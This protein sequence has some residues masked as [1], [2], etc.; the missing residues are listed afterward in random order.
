MNQKH[1]N[2]QAVFTFSVTNPNYQLHQ[3]PKSPH[4]NAPVH[5]LCK[6]IDAVMS[7]A[8]EAETGAGFLN[9]KDAIHLRI[10]LEEMGHPQGPTP[11][12]FDNKVAT[13]LLNDDATQKRSKAMDMRFYW[14]KDRDVQKQFHIHWRPGSTNLADYPTKHHPTSHHT[15]VR[16]NY[17]SNLIELKNRCTKLFGP[18]LQGCAKSLSPLLPPHNKTN[19][20]FQP[21]L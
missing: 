20:H 19:G 21:T 15:T 3:I 6:I 12:Q 10:A 4:P 9:A 2:E 8:Q 1:D 13:Q 5:I 16:H 11:L 18:T 14:L 7:S 17:V